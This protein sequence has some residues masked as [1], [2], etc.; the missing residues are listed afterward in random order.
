VQHARDTGAKTNLIAWAQVSGGGLVLLLYAS[1][2]LIFAF[3]GVPP[4]S[5]G[6]FTLALGVLTT[7]VP[8]IAGFFYGNATSANAANARIDALAARAAP[9]LALPAPVT[10][11]DRLKGQQL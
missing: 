2:L 8:L 1:L 7:L 5:S 4:D 9:V 6:I 11:A 10:E 3:R